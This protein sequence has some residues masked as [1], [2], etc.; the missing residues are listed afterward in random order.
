MFAYM[1]VDTSD[2]TKTIAREYQ[3][4]S[5]CRVG[6]I[7]PNDVARKDLRTPSN[8]TPMAQKADDSQNDSG[9]EAKPD[10]QNGT[11]PEHYD[12]GIF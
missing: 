9:W 8:Y 1:S 6:E 2:G 3:N 11:G 12:T 7:H 4:K 10:C 5:S